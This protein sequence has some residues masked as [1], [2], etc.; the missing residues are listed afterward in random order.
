MGHV[1][2]LARVAFVVNGLP[3][4]ALGVAWPF[5]RDAWQAPLSALGIPEC[6]SYS[7]R[8]PDKKPPSDSHGSHGR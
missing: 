2:A 8:Y 6:P 4:G 3:A 5:M 7:P 1:T